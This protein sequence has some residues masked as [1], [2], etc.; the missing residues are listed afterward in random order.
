MYFQARP[1]EPSTRIPCTLRFSEDEEISESEFREQL[2]QMDRRDRQIQE[3]MENRRTGKGRPVLSLPKKTANRRL[4]YYLTE[5]QESRYSESEPKTMA[6]QQTKENTQDRHGYSE[7]KQ[8]GDRRLRYLPSE[9]Q[10]SRRYN[11]QVAF[12]EQQARKS[13][14]TSSSSSSS[15]TDD[16]EN[17]MKHSRHSAQK[18]KRSVD[19]QM[20]DEEWEERKQ[21]LEQRRKERAQTT[22][23]YENE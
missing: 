18:C 17:K 23:L 14:T 5:I 2:S 4:P 1:K 9:D 21:F 22:Q 20:N 8:M 13:Q 15:E 11:E 16:S 12:C 6:M 19:R 7:P 3:D 10:Y